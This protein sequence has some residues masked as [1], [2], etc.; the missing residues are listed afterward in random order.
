[1]DN[2]EN[3]GFSWIFATRLFGVLCWGHGNWHEA[4]ALLLRAQRLAAEQASAASNP[5]T[6][7]MAGKLSRAAEA[8][9]ADIYKQQ[10]SLFPPKAYL[11]VSIA[12]WANGRWYLT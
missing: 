4:L 8:A 2:K 9:V 12:D 3:I 1:M 6:A 5:K 11:C 10:P 7:Q